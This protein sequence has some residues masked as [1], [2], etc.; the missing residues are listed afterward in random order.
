MFI[1]IGLYVGFEYML[2]CQMFLEKFVAML[3]YILYLIFG[4]PT[5]L[6][7]LIFVVKCKLIGNKVW[8]GT[9]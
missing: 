2:E 5:K 8:N 1:D 9:N 3:F 7:Y 4:I 6:L